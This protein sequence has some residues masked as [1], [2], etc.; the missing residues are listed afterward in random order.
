VSPSQWERLLE[1][2]KKK[3]AQEVE[4]KRLTNI[5]NNMGGFLAKL[6][7]TDEINRKAIETCLRAFAGNK[8]CHARIVNH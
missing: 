8:S 5:M 7:E 1:A 3:M 6:T 2:R 4:V